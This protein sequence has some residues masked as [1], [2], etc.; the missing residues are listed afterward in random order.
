MV[1][2]SISGSTA[3]RVAAF[4][5]SVFTPISARAR[6]LGAINMGQGFP[7]FDGPSS[8]REAAVEAIRAGRNQYA[9]PHGVPELREAIAASF[10]LRSGIAADPDREV[11]VTSG[12]TEAMASV[13]LG[14]IEP[15]DEVVVIEPWYDQYPA[16]IAMAGGVLRSLPLRGD[17]FQLDPDEVRRTITDRTRAVLVNTPHNPTGRVLSRDELGM[18][19]EA[20]VR[21]DVLAITDE[22]YEH[23]VFDHTHHFLAACDGMRERT[24]TLSSLGKSFDLTGWKIGWAVAPP[25]YTAAIRAAHQFLVYASPTPLQV[26]AAHALREGETYFEAY[27][28]AYRRRRDLLCEG[29]LRAGFKLHPPEGTYFV[30]ADHRAFGR[31]DDV[32]FCTFMLEEAGVAAIPPS[33]FSRTNGLM[34]RWVRFAFCKR[35]ETIRAAVARLEE[36]LR[37]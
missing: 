15:G 23:L 16:V 14:V 4:G 9:M 5:E 31:G 20:C 26:A 3:Q 6:E 27:R 17:N 12:C 33:A 18:I 11:T 37:A 21:H 1:N 22:V 8:I 30:M 35:E 19:A 24:I 25:A 28:R 13:M 34:S 7:D 10:A 36:R 2:A 32:A 29:L